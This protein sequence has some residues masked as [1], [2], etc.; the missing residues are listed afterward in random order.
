[1][2]PTTKE[3]ERIAE[4]EKEKAAQAE[5]IAGLLHRIQEL[6]LAKPRSKSRDQAEKG[7]A[8]L[9][10][11]PVALAR[12]ATLNPKYPADVPYNV[13]NL[14]KT[15]VKTVRLS[16][17][18]VY[19]LQA[20]W[21]RYQDGLAKEKAEREAAGKNAKEEVPQAQASSGSQARAAA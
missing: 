10:E 9:K 1:M 8:W 4:L 15:D 18:T 14:L 21:Q 11:G 20:D 6:E 3:A 16:T 12:F 19:M 7:L 13:R 17:G 5:Q 2:K